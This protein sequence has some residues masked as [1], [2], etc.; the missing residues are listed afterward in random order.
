[1]NMTNTY[2]IKKIIIPTFITAAFAF[3]LCGC[4]DI[5]NREF[6]PEIT[7]QEEEN[8]GVGGILLITD[9]ESETDELTQ[10]M[11][12]RP[13]NVTELSFSP[14]QQSFIDS[15]LFMGDSIC[16]GLGA[17]GLVESCYA[18]AGVAARNIEE[19][20][21]E[22][23]GA[24]VEPLTAIVNSGKKNLVFIMGMNDV[25]IENPEEFTVYYDSFLS[26]VEALCPDAS[27][28]VLSI[29]PVTEDSSFCYNYEIDGFNDVLK[30]MITNSSSAARHFVDISVSLK[31]A[32]GN[33]MPE[34]TAAADGVHLVKAAYYDILYSL[35]EGAGVR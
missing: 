13:E 21:F 9:T 17:N 4:V 1:M 6:I 12:T 22:H 5:S 31:N 29:T 14:E 27:L 7:S 2:L 8:A 10:S 35:C 20:T 25:N 3:T 11:P 30:D 24:Q 18:K 26:R 28:Y 32:D 23:G 34:Y 16:S 33:L 15:C 19:F